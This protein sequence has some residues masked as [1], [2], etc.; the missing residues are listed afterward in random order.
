MI[1]IERLRLVVAEALSV[2][3]TVK[4]NAPAADGVPVIEP[5]AARVSPAGGDPDH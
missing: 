1:A 5:L 2:T 4:E 3:V